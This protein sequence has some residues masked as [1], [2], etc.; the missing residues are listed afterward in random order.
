[1]YAESADHRQHTV[2]VLLTAQPC[3]ILCPSAHHSLYDWPLLL[4]KPVS[5]SA[6]GMSLSMSSEDYIVCGALRAWGGDVEAPLMLPTRLLYLKN[7]HS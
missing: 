3:S 5:K 6:W 7:V 4:L 1:M 2:V